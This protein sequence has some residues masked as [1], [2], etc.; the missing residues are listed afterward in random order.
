MPG[1]EDRGTFKVSDGRAVNLII[2]VLWTDGRREHRRE[3]TNR[4]RNRY[5]PTTGMK[6]GTGTGESRNLLDGERNGSGTGMGAKK[7]KKKKIKT[8]PS[9]TTTTTTTDNVD[10]D[11]PPDEAQ[12]KLRSR[13]WGWG[14]GTNPRGDHRH[15]RF[16]HHHDGTLDEPPPSDIPNND[17]SKYRIIHSYQHSKNPSIHL[18]ISDCASFI[19]P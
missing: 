8:Y 5:R 6:P 2:H 11:P 18:L 7:Q 13:C 3:G 16:P 9:T 17:T 15:L 10:M 12:L 19:S 4:N 14:W 1:Q